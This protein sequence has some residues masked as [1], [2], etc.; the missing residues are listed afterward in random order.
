MPSYF[1]GTFSLG[2]SDSNSLRTDRDELLEKITSETIR[3]A[4][5]SRD[6]LEE[7]SAEENRSVFDDRIESDMDPTHILGQ[8]RA[9]KTEEAQA[10]NRIAALLASP[11]HIGDDLLALE[12][13]QRLERAHVSSL[14]ALVASSTAQISVRETAIR[15][16]LLEIDSD[17]EMAR[18]LHERAARAK[19]ELTMS[20]VASEPMRHLEMDQVSRENTW[21]KSRVRSLESEI[22]DAR[23]F[24]EK[25][26]H[27]F[28]TS[29]RIER[30]VNAELRTE[31]R[32]LEREV[33]ALEHACL[34]EERVV[35]ACE[36]HNHSVGNTQLRASLELLGLE[37]AAFEASTASRQSEE[38]S[39]REELR[40]CESNTDRLKA[41]ARQHDQYFGAIT[42]DIRGEI[43]YLT[44]EV[45]E[46]Q[47]QE[48]RVFFGRVP[49]GELERSSRYISAADL[50]GQGPCHGVGVSAPWPLAASSERTASFRTRQLSMG[51]RHGEDVQG[52]L[53]GRVQ[54]EFLERG[55][56]NGAHQRVPM[57]AVPCNETLTSP[58]ST[59]L[60]QRARGSPAPAT[61]TRTDRNMFNGHPS[62]GVQ[63]VRLRAEHLLGTGVQPWARE[64]LEPHGREREGIHV[65]PCG[66]HRH[67]ARFAT[68]C[69]ETLQSPE[70]SPAPCRARRS[71]SAV[72]GVSSCQN[73]TACLRTSLVR[74]EPWRWPHQTSTAGIGRP[75]D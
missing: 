72:C 54:D 1:E 3:R 62:L 58:D 21:L 14:K 40:V 69:H 46:H 60:P 19:D 67:V 65:G 66:A 38:R 44:T 73:N 75:S 30:D 4:S 7:I 18:Q 6:L 37:D 24:H 52:P 50:L 59:P 23:Q 56:S 68:A 8:I 22:S 64:S 16:F 13:N 9:A 48:Q 74:E 45:Q 49:C 10:R 27:N 29:V 25:Q 43:A 61:V 20:S 32:H 63:S 51:T 35:R 26:H 15:R 12:A 31:S 41:E 17:E 47:E 11:K 53:R 39:L 42:A 70:N 36:L 55:A 28:L 71:E 57:G 2:D 33:S 5:T 34:S